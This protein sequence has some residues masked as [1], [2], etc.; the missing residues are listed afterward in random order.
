MKLMNRLSLRQKLIAVAMGG[1]GLALVGSTAASGFYL[2]IVSAPLDLRDFVDH[3][4]WAIAGT[5]A[6][7]AI[8]MPLSIRRLQSFITGPIV[9]LTEMAGQ[10]A[11]QKN[12][13]VRAAKQAEDEIGQLIDRFNDMLGEIQ[14]RESQLQAAREELE[15]RVEERTRELAREQARFRLIFETVPIGITWMNVGDISSRIVNPAHAR[16]TGVAAEFRREL[17]RYREATFPEDRGVQDELHRRL[18]AG[19]IGHYEI[20]KRYLHSDRTIIW[21]ALTVILVRENDA[22]QE[23]NTLVDI[24]ERKRAEMKFAE[25][26]ALLETLLDNSTDTI[27]FKD[28]ESRFV[29]VS[30][31]KINR[32]KDRF[33]DLRV[34]RANLSLPVDVPETDL[35]RGL[36]DFDTYHG[37][38]AK[39]AFADEQE[40]IRSGKAL[41]DKLER[42]VFLDGTV[43]WHLTTKMPWRNDAGQIIGTFGISKDVTAVKEAEAKLEEMHRQ[44]LDASR[45]AGMA[46]IA[47]GVLHN[48]GNV[49]NSVNVSATVVAEHIRNTRAMSIGKLAALFSQHKGDLAE[50]MTKDPRG[51]MVPAYLETL[52]EAI[53]SE[54]TMVIGELEQLRKNIEHIKDIVAM[55]QSYARTAGVLETVSIPDLIED[56]LRINAGSLARHDVQTVRD[57]Q[58]RPVVTTDKHKIIQILINLVRNA[59][60]A[61]DESGRSDKK[62]VVRTTAG[63]EGV[64]IV[65]IDN[66]VGIPPENLSRI[67]SHGFT[68]RVNGHGFGLH[69]G[70][71]AA[72][73][74]GGSLTVASDGLGKGATFTLFVPLTCEPRP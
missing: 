74:L 28:R 69:S 22:V 46:E 54:H 20:E 39:I 68:T 27:Y 52:A 63:E 44:L 18:L 35:L 51:Q 31:S 56:A 2:Y 29:R 60:Y 16:I 5:L 25:A 71:L 50:F 64:N 61:C 58:A 59:K 62:I 67:F 11:A 73:E 26:S 34:I 17:Q 33:S 53:G 65:V 66:G 43:C 12:Y 48:V 72:K 9:E 70:A 3:V 14:G 10:I 41:V 13:G 19:E 23:I 7:F 57:Y 21:V 40:I 6:V 47:T 42:Q 4:L 37:D 55:Q 38:D 1:A 24:T 45:H 36:T 30:R 49:L 15:R 8:V 32:L